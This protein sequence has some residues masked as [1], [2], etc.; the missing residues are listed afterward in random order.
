MARKIAGDEVARFRVT[1]REVRELLGR[2]RVHPGE[3]AHRERG[4]CRHRHVLHPG[5]GGHPLRGSQ[6]HAGGVTP[7]SDRPGLGTSCRSREG[8][9]GPWQRASG[10]HTGR[11]R[12]RSTERKSIS[13]SPRARCRRTGR[14]P[15]S[16]WPSPSSPRLSRRKVRRDVAMTGELTLTG[17]VLPIG[18]VKEKILGAV[19]AGIHEIHP[20]RRQRGRPRGHPR[21][22]ARHAYPCTSSGGST[23]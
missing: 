23:R 20:P 10:G 3:D 9:P 12:S 14:R 7:R 6:R 19:R 15:G 21:R 5:R 13:T 16:R 1:P 18:G 22:G 8:R 17:R 11:F 2:P 4:R